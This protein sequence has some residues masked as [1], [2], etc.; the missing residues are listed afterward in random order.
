MELTVKRKGIWYRWKKMLKRDWHLILL[1]VPA[2][3]FIFIFDYG[4][5]YGIQIAFKDYNSR[6]GIWGSEWV[7]FEHFIRFFNSPNFWNILRNTLSISFYSLLASFP[8]PILL[9][10]LVNQVTKKKFKR[11]VQMVLYAPHF[12]SVIVLCGMLHV[13]LSPSTGIVNNILASLGMERIYFLGEA[14]LF[15]DVFVWSGVWQN[16][17]WGMIIYLAALTSIDPELYEAAKIDG[18]NKIKLITH[19]EIP[20][21]MPTIV[22]ML[23]MNVGRFMN[24]GFQKAFLLQNPL[25]LQSSEIISTYVYRMGMLGQQFSFSTAIGLF[26]NVVNIILLITVNQICKKLNETSLW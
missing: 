21:I 2:L 4:P 1:C 25:N 24:V 7:G 3:I 6:K 22:I 26:N 12:I 17:G 5:M 10:L 23:I 15:N 8:F 18:A 16:S 14:A 20:Q 13:F 9:A 11:T 19:I